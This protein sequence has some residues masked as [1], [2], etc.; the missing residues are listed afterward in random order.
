MTVVFVFKDKRIQ[1]FLLIYI[2]LTFDLRD[3]RDVIR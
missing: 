2:L 3:V 1:S